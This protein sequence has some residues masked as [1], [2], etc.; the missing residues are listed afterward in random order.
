M[1]DHFHHLLNPNWPQ[2]FWDVSGAFTHDMELLFLHDFFLKNFGIKLFSLVHG[3]PL[4]N[5]NSGRVLPKLQ[6]SE[7]DIV[8]C[9]RGY[10]QRKISLDLTFSN[11][12][13]TEEH[14]KSKLGNALLNVSETNNPG[15]NNGVIMSSD[16]LY[17]HVK[18]NYPGL[19]K[20]SSIIK[21]TNEKGGGKLDYYLKLAE[22]YDKVMV[23]PND[24]DNFEFLAKLEQKDKYEILVNENC[25]R[26]CT[27]RHKHYDSLSKTSL[28]L[29]GHEDNFESLR[30]KNGCSKPFMLLSRSKICTTQ[31]SPLELK[32]L[33]D[34]G[35][36][37][38][39]VQGRGLMNSGG[40]IFD[41]LR[42]M[43]RPDGPDEY[44][45]TDLKA[46]FLESL[47]TSSKVA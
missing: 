5:W 29:L 17:N 4:F 8:A 14:I 46:L 45:M 41:M 30:L 6:C 26:Q 22:K 40:Q 1:S 43:L 27:M 37:K 16:V 3:S 20:V 23:H 25:I 28:N 35:F 36:R 12:Y 32:T 31:L 42:L 19:K 44:Q 10:G 15:G 47:S 13:L 9:F 34:M 38:F 33:Y 2:A 18:T 11:L 21:V 39:K 7:A 24:S